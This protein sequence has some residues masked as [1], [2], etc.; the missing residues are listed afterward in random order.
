MQ[1][2]KLRK[3]H[4]AAGRCVVWNREARCGLERTSIERS[5]GRSFGTARRGTIRGTPSAHI[6]LKTIRFHAHSRHP[7]ARLL[8]RPAGYRKYFPYQDGQAKSAATLKHQR[9]SECRTVQSHRFGIRDAWPQSRKEPYAK[10]SA[11]PTHTTGGRRFPP[12]CMAF[13]GAP[14]SRQSKTFYPPRRLTR[15][16]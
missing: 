16:A 1:R 15:R 6:L 9:T 3:Q 11:E 10:R 8:Q 4:T 7:T 2:L 14:D 12:W 5:H 13:R